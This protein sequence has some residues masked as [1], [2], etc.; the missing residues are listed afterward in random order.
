VRRFARLGSSNGTRHRGEFADI[1]DAVVDQHTENPTRGQPDFPA[2]PT[3]SSRAR[4]A[5]HGSNTL[6]STRP[7][8]TGSPRMTA[9]GT[10]RR[11][12]PL[13]QQSDQGRAAPHADQLPDGLGRE[14]GHDPKPPMADV[15]FAST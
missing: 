7:H 6:T 2:R 8:A 1:E 11:T 14:T 9:R 15:G 5:G 3:D 13:A 4:S 12:E 10:I